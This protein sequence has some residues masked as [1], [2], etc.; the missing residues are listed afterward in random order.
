MVSRRNCQ[1]TGANFSPYLGRGLLYIRQVH[2]VVDV[3][4]RIALV[5]AHA[6]AP[7]GTRDLHRLFQK[8]EALNHLLDRW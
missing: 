7:G 5:H 3:T 2:G 1:D 4:Q 8:T 6:R